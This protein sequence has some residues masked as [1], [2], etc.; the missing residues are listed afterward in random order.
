MKDNNPFEKEIKVAI[1]NHLLEHNT[2][3]KDTTIINELVIDSFSRRAD[4]VVINNNNLIAFEIKSE[5]DSLARLAGQ[6]EKYLF[7]FDKIIVV[8]TKKHIDKIVKSLPD[9][10][11]LWEFSNSAIT[12]KYKGRTKNISEKRYFLDFLKSSDLKKLAKKK[13]IV[14]EY[15]SKGKIKEKIINS[16]NKISFNEIKHFTIQTLK[17][18]YKLSSELFTSN[19]LMKN[20]V[21][22]NDFYLL[23]N[24]TVKKDISEPMLNTLSNIIR[25]DPLLEKLAKDTSLPIFGS[26][27]SQ[28]KKML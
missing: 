18:R 28:I 25:D 4:L 3:T 12:I 11:G 6:V 19:I 22:N 21:N 16:L 27:P 14:L 2:I 9:R 17:K 1:L 8:S 13:N 7:Y 24:H 26:V 15:N 20:K 10:V 5:A 23:K